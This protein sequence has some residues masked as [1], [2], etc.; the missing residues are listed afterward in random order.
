MKQAISQLLSQYGLTIGLILIAW[1]ACGQAGGTSAGSPRVKAQ[2]VITI[3]VYNYAHVGRLELKDAER[4]AAELL[5]AAGERIVWLEFSGKNRLAQASP[6]NLAA[7]LFLRILKASAI[8][9]VR[10][11]SAADVMGEA[12]VAPGSESLVP[13]RFANLF[14]D[15]VQ[16][17]SAL[18]GLFSGQILG[19]AIAHELG[20]LLL[21]S[22]HSPE[23]IMKGHWTLQDL[24]I[25]SHGG[26]PFSQ[27]Q[28]VLL[29]RAAWSLHQDSSPTLAAQR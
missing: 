7:D 2:P 14:Y 17:V 15:R 11:I 22:G 9:R 12:I 8:R 5:A 10:R 25:A 21:G 20:H 6:N 29:Q 1:P 18:W 16:H 3:A 13:G 4:E 28:A 19:D 23:G 24:R 26:L 27:A